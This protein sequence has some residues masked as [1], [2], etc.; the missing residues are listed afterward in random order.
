MTQQMSPESPMASTAA[1]AMAAEMSSIN[2]P[3]D[4]DL[5]SATPAVRGWD[6]LED[7]HNPYNWPKWKKNVQLLTIASIAFTC[8][9]GTSI[10]SPAHQDFMDEFGVSSTV[11]FLPLS[12]YVFS[13]GLGPIVGG[14]LS[15]VAGRRAVF[16]MAVALG[17]LFALGSG[18]AGTFAGL[19]VMRF[20]SGF[21]YGPSLAIG[22][23][24][25]L[26]TYRPIERGPPSA[27]FILSPFLG[28]GLG[29]VLGVF[30]VDRMGWR[31]TQYT[32]V[33]FSVFC[34][35]CMFFSG[36]SYHLVLKRRRMKAL[37]LTPP[38]AAPL[39]A[40]MKK[41]VTVDLFRP[42]HMLLTEPIVTFLCLYIATMFGTLFLFFGAF[43]YVFQKTYNFTL[44]QSGLVFLGI[45]FGCLLGTT[46]VA[47]C[48]V[49]FYRPKA[50][51]H[52]SHQIPP[53]YR[54]YPAKIGSILLPISLFWFGWTTSPGINPAAPIIAIVLFGTG[55][56][57]LFISSM[58]Y[59]GDAYHHSNVA[60]ASSANSLA[61]YTFAAAFPFFCIQM[62]QK[63]GTG[64][65]TSILG[66][67]ALLQLPVP[68]VLS[69]Y[70]KRLRA[71]SKYETSSS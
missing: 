16:I 58:Q 66:F 23:G 13:L 4:K 36:E 69:K 65:A 37:G 35:I 31:W 62:Y 8:S 7:S 22:S 2:E 45:G 59:I 20:L 5:E 24:V 68:W 26:E 15:E 54:L 25:L 47:V 56:I 55:N 38:E 71:L 53:E 3:K 40:T 19:C 50:K 12:L 39:S 49:V 21:F 42:I 52:L 46:M 44:I 6:W 30:L 18:F 61:R 34:A 10:V 1:E 33:F 32:L 28:P 41:F 67:L 64:W 14:P 48:E 60:S 63:L 29:P 51:K 27:L 9:V 43:F 70:G 11:A 57:G 17:G